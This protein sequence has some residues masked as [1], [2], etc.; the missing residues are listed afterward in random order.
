MST[1]ALAFAVTALALL[2]SAI[3]IAQKPSLKKVPA[4]YT[5]PASGEEMY[6]SYCAA[7]HGKDGKGNG[8]AVPALKSLPP[9]LTTLARRNGGKYP[10]DHVY[11]I[12]SG[13]TE[14]AAHGSTDMPVWGPVFMRMGQSHPA[15]VQL[16]ANNLTK[17]LESLQ[18]NG[19]TRR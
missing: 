3:A 10:A 11:A 15:E 4:P 14:L 19:D 2:L 13:K 6:V 7:C 17:Y 18:V 9:D 8:P 1:R 5:S 16:R 12:L